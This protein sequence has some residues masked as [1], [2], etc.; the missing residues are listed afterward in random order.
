M[1]QPRDFTT[2]D[3]LQRVSEDV[4]NRLAGLGISLTGQETPGELVRIQEAVEQFELAVESRGG[5]LMVDEG[6]DGQ[7]SEPD[8]PQFALPVR[9][10]NEPV[11]HY[12]ERLVFATDEVRRQPERE[13]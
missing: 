11:D 7:T 3:E 1:T 4:A 8:D 6:P 10:E 5:G 13:S 12:I 2:N 9:A